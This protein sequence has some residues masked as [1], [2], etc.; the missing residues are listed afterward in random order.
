MDVNGFFLCIDF[1]DSQQ[2]L[3]YFMYLGSVA[4]DT[5]NHI[6]K[7]A[8][9]SAHLPKCMEIVVTCIYEG[10]SISSETHFFGEGR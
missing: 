5:D 10:C 6:S 7:A 1:I 3:H 9:I 2:M 4:S 8:A